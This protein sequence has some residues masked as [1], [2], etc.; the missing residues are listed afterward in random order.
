MLKETNEL[1]VRDMLPNHAFYASDELR[2]EYN[3][4]LQKYYFKG[5]NEFTQEFFVRFVTHPQFN[6]GAGT[7]RAA[8]Q[9]LL[10]VVDEK[11]TAYINKVLEAQKMVE[12]MEKRVQ[13]AEIKVNALTNNVEAKALL[14]PH[15][16]DIKYWIYDEYY[17]CAW[18]CSDKPK[19]NP[20]HGM[21]RELGETFFR[22]ELNQLSEEEVER[23][24]NT[25]IERP[26][27]EEKRVLKWPTNKVWKYRTY[28]PKEKCAWFTKFEPVRD[29]VNSTVYVSEKYIE[30]GELTYFRDT[31]NEV[32]QDDKDNWCK[33]HERGEDVDW[34]EILICNPKVW[35]SFQWAAID[36]DGEVYLHE[37]KPKDSGS[38]Y[39]ENEGD[40]TFVCRIDSTK[41]PLGEWRNLSLPRNAFES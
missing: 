2:N 40:A 28:D 6:P 10:N 33:V 27:K 19:K 5:E 17:K 11:A 3:V 15:N 35:S 16:P 34:P 32:T 21:W 29:V 30:E 1:F 14:W 38:G 24:A 39:W 26:S 25:V 9:L 13:A 23:L 41:I 22:D 31:L 4:L 8:Y 18:F 12:E 20:C 37:E 7:Y 36:C